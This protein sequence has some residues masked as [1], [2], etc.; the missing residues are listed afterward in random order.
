[1][2]VHP[3]KAR[4][5]LF[6]RVIDNL[7][8]I[9][10]SWRLARCLQREHG[11]QV[12]LW[13]DNLQT[14][15]LI[16]HSVDP[17]APSQL[18]DGVEIGLWGDVRASQTPADVV[19]EAFGCGLP[20][21]YLQAMEQAWQG[22]VWIQ[23]EYLSAEPWID[24]FHRRKSPLARSPLVKHF[25][26]PG[27]SA[28]SGGLLHERNLECGREE[29]EQ[30]P[31]LQAAWWAHAGFSAPAPDERRVSLFAYANRAL[32]CL[33]DA[34][35]DD[36][37]QHW[38]VIVPRGVWVDEIEHCLS[39]GF[40]CHG[41]EARKGA[42]TLKTVP[43]FDQDDY[44]RLLWACDLNFVRGEDSF[45]RAQWAR[46]PCVWQIYPQAEAVHQIK[47]DAFLDRY[48]H[49]WPHEAAAHVRAFWHAWNREDPQLGA[50][51]ASYWRTMLSSRSLTA[52]WADS[53]QAQGDLA[54]HLVE[55]AVLDLA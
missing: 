37:E 38:T 20:E 22:T 32:A 42:L 26:F 19:I 28:G 33:L 36:K 54:S 1:M 40:I 50:L 51:W 30:S 13:V 17:R 8:D 43:F 25:F 15:A 31:A 45:V 24:E 35:A 48:L 3:G 16:A 12:R 18:I 53:L 2:D 46:R 21:T 4:W 39:D 14:F 6:C 47:L 44:D 41:T 55:F 7:G 52:A 23:L 34:W 10:V 5:D 9:G 29:F 11:C 49:A 27:F